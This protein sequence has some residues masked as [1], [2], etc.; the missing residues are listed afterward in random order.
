MKRKKTSIKRDVEKAIFKSWAE[1][2]AEAMQPFG[3]EQKRFWFTS[4]GVE[5]R[6]V[7]QGLGKPQGTLEQYLFLLVKSGHVERAE[8]PQKMKDKQVRQKEYL[9]RRTEKPLIPAKR[10]KGGQIG[11]KIYRDNPKLAK[12]FRDMM[13]YE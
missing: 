3:T 4:K 12:W 6:M 7:Y 1:K 10:I 8:K 11:E 5:N 9:Y 13:V 2:V